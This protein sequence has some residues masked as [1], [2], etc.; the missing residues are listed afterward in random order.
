[1]QSY[2]N[3][4]FSFCITTLVGQWENHLCFHT[5]SEERDWQSGNKRFINEGPHEL[6]GLYIL[7]LILGSSGLTL[8]QVQA[9]ATQSKAEGLSVQE[10]DSQEGL[11][12]QDL[13]PAGDVKTNSHTA[14]WRIYTDTGRDLFSQGRLEEAEKYL[15]QA[16]EQAKLGFGEHDQHVASSYQNLAEL[17]RIREDFARAEPLYVKAIDQLKAT[18]GPEDFTVGQAMHNLAGCYL[19]QRNFDMAREYYEQALEIKGKALSTAHPE[20]AN[21]QFHLGEVLRLQG[22]HD[23]AATLMRGSVKILEEG[24]AAHTPSVIR[25]MARLA[26]IL[27]DRRELAEAEKLQRKVIHAVEMVQGP[28]SAA[29]A[30]AS[31]NLA[32]TLL[33]AGRNDEAEELFQSA[34]A[35]R[36]ELDPNGPTVGR[37]LVWLAEVTEQRAQSHEKRGDAQEALQGY[38]AAAELLE[39][40]VQTLEKAWQKAGSALQAALRADATAKRNGSGVRDAEAQLRKAQAAMLPRLQELVRALSACGRVDLARAESKGQIAPEERRRLELTGEAAVRR[41]LEL[42]T[43]YGPLIPGL[44]KPLKEVAV[45]EKVRVLLEMLLSVCRHKRAHARYTEVLDQEIAQLSSKLEAVK[46]AIEE[47]RQLERRLSDATRKQLDAPTGW[48]AWMKLKF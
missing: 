26:E 3:K 20:Y 42:L 30:T 16:L 48:R 10:G 33:V 5:T 46:M 28:K 38:E 12:V 25:K 31:E 41:A 34:L 24:G 35:L 6:R 2:R 22:R 13:R 29:L 18:V 39:P 1:M 17:Y 43:E 9:D 7:L 37:A 44:E 19:V 23:D 11:Q 36:K 21:T 45:Q 15:T 4:R 8:T 47:A 32:A 40:A 27:V 14:R